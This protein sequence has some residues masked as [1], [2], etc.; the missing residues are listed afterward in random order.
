MFA[1]VA[2]WQ[3]SSFVM[4]RLQV[5][6]PSPA[7]K[8]SKS[9]DLEFFYPSRQAWYIIEGITR[10]LRVIPSYIINN[11][12]PLLYIIT[13]SGVYFCRLDDIQLLRSWWYAIPD[14][15]DDIHGFAVIKNKRCYYHRARKKHFGRSAFFNEINPFRDLWNIAS[16]Y[17][18]A[19]AMKY[20]SAYEGF[21]LFH[22]LR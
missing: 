6:F 5:R 20:A 8:N 4:S 12:K 10:L 18:I 9:S 3:S 11:G 7:P 13:P 16:R 14:G 2:Q 19:T 21:I 15:I 1:G 22:F 17:E